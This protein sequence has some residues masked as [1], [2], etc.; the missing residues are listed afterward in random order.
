MF[1]CFLFRLRDAI[2]HRETPVIA[3][4]SGLGHSVDA[5]F[6]ALVF[7]DFL[8]CWWKTFDINVWFHHNLPQSVGSASEG[9]RRDFVFS[10]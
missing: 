3:C 10:I 1:P 6:V 9:L 2:P 7:F 4:I 8:L 5:G